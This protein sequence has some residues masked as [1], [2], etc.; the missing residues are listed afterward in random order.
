[1]IPSQQDIVDTLSKEIYREETVNPPKG[2]TSPRTTNMGGCYQHDQGS[3]HGEEE[4]DE[5]T[6]RFPILDT[7]RNVTMKNMH[8]FV[9]SNFHGMSTKDPHAFLFEFG[10]F[11]QSYNYNHDA[12]KIKLFPT[13]LADSSPR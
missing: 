12:N 3:I 7:T 9:L 6:F 5:A 11:S 2:T 4:H 1:M 8:P 13:T 10:V